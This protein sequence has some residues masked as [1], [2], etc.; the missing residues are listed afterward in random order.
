MQVNP[1]RL[2]GAARIGFA[3]KGFVAR[4]VELGHR[5]IG[6]TGTSTEQAIVK[7]VAPHPFMAPAAYAAEDAAIEAFGECLAY[8]NREI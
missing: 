8:M 3:K 5:E 4:F 7:E 6:H 1:E 2:E